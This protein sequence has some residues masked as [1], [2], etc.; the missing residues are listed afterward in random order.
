MTIL[1][2]LEARLGRT[3]DGHIVSTSGVDAHPFWRRYLAVFDRVLIA[4]RVEPVADGPGLAPVEGPGVAVRALPPYRG[5]WQYLRRRAELAHAMRAAVAEADVLCLRA[6]GPVAGAAW[7][8]RAGRPFGVEVVGDPEDSLSAGAVRS[9]ARVPARAALARDLGAMCREAVAVS[10]VTRRALQRRYPTTAW[11]TSYSS[12]DLP[13]EAFAT[14]AELAARSARIARPGKG[15]AADP[16]RL[17]T[18]GTL[19]QLYKGQDVLIDAFRIARAR[20]LAA[21]LTVV[22]DGACRPALEARAGGVAV[23]FA[24][25]LP[26]GAAVRAALDA[27][28]VFVLASRG[29]GLPRA[30]IEAMAR[31]C[32][33]L[34]T[35]VGGIPE[36]LPDDR[37]VRPGNARALAHALI[38]LCA[39]ATDL[40]GLGQRDRTVARGYHSSVLSERRREFYRRLRLAAAEN[41]VL[42]EA[43]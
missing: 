38:R 13:E 41:V 7:R 42:R 31:G 33:G 18:V 4:A 30:L 11:T 17:V 15:T 3:P 32:P 2:A 35:R 40:A 10:Y 39:R 9:L 26:A 43:G 28:D 23:H 16:W 24:G 37:L 29:E 22:G 25:H 27:A 34:A 8:L 6:P 12:I 1:V 14:D 19:A 36:L 21:E 5:P 20:G